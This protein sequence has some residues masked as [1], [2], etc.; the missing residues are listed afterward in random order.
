[1]TGADLKYP[2][3]LTA[4]VRGAFV[5]SRAVYGK[6]ARWPKGSFFTHSEDDDHNHAGDARGPSVGKCARVKVAMRVPSS[7]AKAHPHAFAKCF[8]RALASTSNTTVPLLGGNIVPKS[9]P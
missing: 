9:S 8:A 7:N 4:L 1:M 5:A 2:S 3:T 6:V